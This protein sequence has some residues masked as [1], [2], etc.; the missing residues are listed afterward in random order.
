MQ[1]RKQTI[2]RRNDAGGRGGFTVLELVVVVGVIIALVAATLPAFRAISDSNRVSGSKNALA[3]TLGTARSLAMQRGH[4]V[5]VMFG[6]DVRTQVT[7]LQ[8]IEESGTTDDAGNGMGAA[9]IF[10]PVDGQAV[11][12]LPRGAGVL[13]YGYGASRGSADPANPWNWYCDLGRLYVGARKN[14]DPWLQPRTDIRFFATDGDITKSTDANAA[15]L[16]TFIVR[17]SPD[18]T[19]VTN[20]EELGS[21]AAGGD[22]FVDLDKA[23]DADADGNYRQWTPRITTNGRGEKVAIAEAQLRCV[24]FVVIVDLIK[25]GDELGIRKPWLMVGPESPYAATRYQEIADRSDANEDGKEDQIQMGEWMDANA[26]AQA[27]NRFTGLLLPD[28][29]VER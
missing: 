3:A 4:D 24:P 15:N 13:G 14:F 7:T 23:T 5:A 22:A 19:I 6:F 20:S 11:I 10:V 29:E 8:L 1:S 12:E 27:F 2:R 9:T 25:V 28:D 18:G 17:Y 26:S 21:S 16:E